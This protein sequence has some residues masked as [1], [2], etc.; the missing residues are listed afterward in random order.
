M[1]ERCPYK[2]VVVGPIP[3]IPKM[4]LELG[5]GERLAE[6]QEV[7]G[8]NPIS[9]NL[10]INSLVYILLYGKGCN[11]NSRLTRLYNKRP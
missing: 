1:V 9:P 4:G 2:A 11:K 3:A 6:D 8:S 10:F 7:M 5:L